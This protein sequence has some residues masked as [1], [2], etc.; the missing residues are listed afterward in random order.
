M[1]NW[2]IK[3]LGGFTRKE[4]LEKVAEYTIPRTFASNKTGADYIYIYDL[5]TFVLKD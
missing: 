3:K 5:K 1:R 2:I 4:L